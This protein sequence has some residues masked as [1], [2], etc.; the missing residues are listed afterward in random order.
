M[1]D[2]NPSYVI[3][4]G[5]RVPEFGR[6]PVARL[7]AFFERYHDRILFGTD[8]QRIPAGFVLGSVGD[9]LNTIGDVAPFF[10]SHWRFF[11]TEDVDFPH[12]SPI[13]GDWTISGIHLPRPILEDIYH[14]NAERVFGLELPADDPPAPAQ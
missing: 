14:R 11:E 10:D 3:E 4:T 9:E 8:F 12:P 6:H 2:A 7:K 13:Q 5:A 1:L